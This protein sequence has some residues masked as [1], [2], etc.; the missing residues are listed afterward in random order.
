MYSLLVVDDENIIRRGIRALVD[1]P[2]LG[3]GACFEASNGEEARSSWKASG[4]I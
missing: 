1:F 2:G 3:I 4:S